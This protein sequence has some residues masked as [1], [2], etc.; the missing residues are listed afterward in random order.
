MVSVAVLVLVMLAVST[1]FNTVTQTSSLTTADIEISDTVDAIRRTMQAD[2]NAL[3]PG[4][5]LLFIPGP[6]VDD[7]GDPLRDLPTE[8]AVAQARTSALTFLASGSPGQFES[9]WNPQ[10][11]SSEA[12]I[13][14]R[15]GLGLPTDG[16]VW[17]DPNYTLDQVR[18]A[19][20]TPRMMFNRILSRRAIL[21]VPDE[22]TGTAE[23]DDQWGHGLGE[24][25]YY[26]PNCLGIDNWGT[27]DAFEQL[28]QSYKL[29]LV[30]VMQ[31][32]TA[33]KFIER[34]RSVTGNYAALIADNY[35]PMMMPVRPEDRG[36][37]CFNL[38]PH[39]GEF[40]IEW[41]DGSRVN[42]DPTLPI[43]WFGLGRDM[44]GDGDVE[45]GTGDVISYYLYRELG[46]Q[47]GETVPADDVI[48]LTPFGIEQGMRSTPQNEAN[49]SVPYGSS[50]GG[51][52]GYWAVWSYYNWQYRPKL[53]RVTLWL[54]DS[55]KRIR[56]ATD[57]NSPEQALY[58]D[59]RLGQQRSFIL[60]VP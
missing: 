45:P 3:A 37:F 10:V 31:M 41:T 58:P 38:A 21:L 49:P 18:S 43:Q 48:H 26:P 1:I 28:H 44:D 59:E 17:G 23:L 46:L 42:N 4:A 27:A 25:L 34:L 40:I 52:F 29:S 53:L 47:T 56:K 11:T 30:D 55:N 5:M 50:I 51:G 8:P 13:T 15:H 6:E 12:F 20:R 60:E 2:L 54:Y 22:L 16:P 57:P 35:T 7:A 33:A 32:R 9:Y 19:L 39:I 24:P 36:Q 14:Y